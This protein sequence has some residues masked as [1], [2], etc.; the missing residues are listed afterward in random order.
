VW[1]EC[2]LRG[3]SLCPVRSLAAEG[4]EQ[5]LEGSVRDLDLLD[6]RWAADRQ[7]PCLKGLVTCDLWPKPQ[8]RSK[9]AG[10]TRDRDGEQIQTLGHDEPVKHALNAPA[11]W[12]GGTIKRDSACGDLDQSL[13]MRQR[14][15]Y[16][17]FARLP[18]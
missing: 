5:S 1:L 10:V 16:S 6:G 18:V 14:H 9:G 2:T 11:Q 4:V 15:L 8:R 12:Q 7:L 17:L 13:S 3:L